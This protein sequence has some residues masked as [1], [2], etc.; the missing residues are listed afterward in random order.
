[1]GE[2][3]GHRGLLVHH[4]GQALAVRAVQRIERLVGIEFDPLDLVDLCR[5]E[6]LSR[7]NRLDVDQVRRTQ[8]SERFRSQYRRH[9]DHL[10]TQVNAS[11]CGWVQPAVLMA[12]RF[13]SF[14]GGTRET[15]M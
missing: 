1:M 13:T 7:R 9:H 4:H 11:R 12:M 2:G 14:A 6:D 3:G 8:R 5:A 10:H 15:S